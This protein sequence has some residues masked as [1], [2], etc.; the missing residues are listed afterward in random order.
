MSVFRARKVTGG[1]HRKFKTS[2]GVYCCL[3]LSIWTNFGTIQSLKG[4]IINS[5]EEDKGLISY[6]DRNEAVVIFDSEKTETHHEAKKKPILY[7]HVGPPKT[8]TTT[9]QAELTKY[10]DEL[11]GDDIVY[12]G[13]GTNEKWVKGNDGNKFPHPSWC[14]IYLQYQE[15]IEGISPNCFYRM[16]ETIHEYHASGRDVIMSDEVVGLMFA[17]KDTKK[18]KKKKRALK[19]LKKFADLFRD[20]WDIRILLGYRPYFD[21][22][23]SQFN[24]KWEIKPGKPKKNKW[25]ARGGQSVPLV[26]DSWDSTGHV[27]NGWSSTI[28]LA[29]VFS[30]EFDNITIFDIT[31]TGDLM[32]YFLCDILENAHQ[33]C[34]SKK[35]S[36]ASGTL[37]AKKNVASPLDYD[38]LA[39]AASKKGLFDLTL[40]RRSVV[41]KVKQHHEDELGLKVIDLPLI[42]PSTS[43]TTAL[44][45]ASIAQEKRLFPDR[46]EEGG[47]HQGSLKA[48]FQKRLDTKAF[49]NIDVGKILED[50]TW[51]EFFKSL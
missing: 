38:M 33:A 22:V 37:D 13:K 40:K 39:T 2:L 3:A 46:E 28:E 31:R 42:C 48:T 8:A 25:P 34:E 10:R 24:E 12:L 15:K 19:G 32:T 17:A 16:N 45:N 11:L 23:T 47:A 1:K 26:K 18:K 36:V 4:S 5:G 50:E 35:S 14:T 7:L 41:A 21:F 44:F 51:I 43:H 30:R 27:H 9:I 49:C 20:D 29:N 6:A